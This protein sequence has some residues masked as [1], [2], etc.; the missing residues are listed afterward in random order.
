MSLQIAFCLYVKT[1]LRAKMCFPHSFNS[2]FHMS[3]VQGLVLN[4]RHK[5][6]RKQ[7]IPIY[8]ISLFVGLFIIY[9]YTPVCYRPHTVTSRA[10]SCCSFR[11]NMFTICDLRDLE[12]KKRGGWF[13]SS[14]KD[15]TVQRMILYGLLRVIHIF[16]T[17]DILTL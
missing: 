17:A 15:V 11:L 12:N 6:I 7:L 10:C 14:S 8:Y 16:L 1:S 4:Q 13:L 2:H 9:L 5:R 3:F